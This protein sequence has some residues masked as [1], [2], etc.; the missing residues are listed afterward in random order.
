MTSKI[1]GD[2]RSNPHSAVPSISSIL[3]FLFTT[4]NT[5]SIQNLQGSR[6]KHNIQALRHCFSPWKSRKVWA[7]KELWLCWDGSESSWRMWLHFQIEMAPESVKLS[8]SLDALEVDSEKL[9]KLCLFVLIWMTPRIFRN[10]WYVLVRILT[11]NYCRMSHGVYVLFCFLFC[12]FFLCPTHLSF[13]LVGLPG[14]KYM[15]P[16]R[17]W[18]LFLGAEIRVITGRNCDQSSPY[19]SD[20]QNV[21]KART[22]KQRGGARTCTRYGRSG[23]RMRPWERSVLLWYTWWRS[24]CT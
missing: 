17:Y 10:T 8:S 16:L 13:C 2:I 15:Q 6:D 21:S 3:T 5:V 20:L 24:A 23:P 4:K 12:F 11:G 14:T 19:L 1:C 7:T 18:K 9:W 22:L